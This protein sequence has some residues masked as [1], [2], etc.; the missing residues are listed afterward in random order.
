MILGV[1][2]RLSHLLPAT[3][4]PIMSKRTTKRRMLTH[5]ILFT[6]ESPLFRPGV[7]IRFPEFP[8]IFEIWRLY[9]QVGKSLPDNFGIH[10]TPA[11]G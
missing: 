4:I 11:F 9:M 7:P 6:Q 2:N 5:R 1:Q 10:E 3:A 8:G